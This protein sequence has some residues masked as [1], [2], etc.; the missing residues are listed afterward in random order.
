MDPI[1]DPTVRAGRLTPQSASSTGIGGH[2][3][4]PPMV[5]S[6]AIVKLP[7]Y[8][9]TRVEL[10]FEL[11][12]GERRARRIGRLEPDVAGCGHNV[13]HTHSSHRSRELPMGVVGIRF[14]MLGGSGVVVN[15]ASYATCV[16][17]YPRNESPEVAACRYAKASA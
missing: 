7:N 2:D 8:P 15:C 13:A 11:L 3:Q 10:S 17:G 6:V 1:A 9:S 4:S 12:H 16:C 5:R 14:A